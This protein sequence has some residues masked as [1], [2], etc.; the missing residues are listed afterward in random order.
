MARDGA[1]V[2]EV[3][4]RKVEAVD[5]TAAGDTFAGVLIAF[6][7]E[8]AALEDA[9]DAAT[10]AASISVTRPGAS[11]SMPTRAEIDREL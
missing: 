9:L 11:T 7:A 1:V 3:A 4:P 8:G 10:V 6:L 2:T 5:T